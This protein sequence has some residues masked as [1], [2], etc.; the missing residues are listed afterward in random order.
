MAAVREGLLRLGRLAG[1]AVRDRVSSQGK[2]R[3]GSTWQHS[4]A[5]PL[6]PPVEYLKEKYFTQ[7]NGCL[8]SPGGD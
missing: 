7:I 4:R 3:L 1:K 2:T 6:P 8:C 5:C